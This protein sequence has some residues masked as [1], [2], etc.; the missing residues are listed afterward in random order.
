VHI[1][2]CRS[3][4]FRSFHFLAAF[5]PNYFSRVCF[6]IFIV[7]RTLIISSQQP[8]KETEEAASNIA[9]SENEKKKHLLEFYWPASVCEGEKES[10]K[11]IT[12][13]QFQR[14]RT[15]NVEFTFSLPFAIVTSH[16]IA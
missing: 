11:T 6:F 9:A 1:L 16:L 10:M 2:P 7:R 12:V 15:K 14:R 3:P 13:F 8:A 4:F 5:L